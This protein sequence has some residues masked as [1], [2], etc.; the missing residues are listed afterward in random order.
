MA[1]SFDGNGQA[2]PTMGRRK[3]ATLA[4][5]GGFEEQLEGLERE[6]GVRQQL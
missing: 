3:R 6:A 1:S 2:A 4:M 5:R